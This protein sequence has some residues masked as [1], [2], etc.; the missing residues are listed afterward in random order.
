LNCKDA[1]HHC[2]LI[3]G[4]GITACLGIFVRSTQRNLDA[5]LFNNDISINN[6]A[7]V[8]FAKKIPALFSQCFIRMGRFVDETLDE[9]LDKFTTK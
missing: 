3:N 1:I 7:M 6:A 5:L 2:R 8:L 4:L 9:V